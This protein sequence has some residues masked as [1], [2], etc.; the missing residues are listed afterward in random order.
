[1]GG[2][3][4]APARFP[5]GPAAAGLG[6]RAPWRWVSAL[7]G[8]RPGL[9]SQVGGLLQTPWGRGGEWGSRSLGLPLEPALVPP[10]AGP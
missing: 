9:R 8:V 10:P 1:M 5:L 2:R 3:G 6:R 4:V 7:H